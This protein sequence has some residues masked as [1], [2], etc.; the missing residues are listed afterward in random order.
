M[1]KNV[2]KIFLKWHT[3]YLFVLKRFRTSRMSKRR[4]REIAYYSLKI[5]K[6]EKEIK[7]LNLPGHFWLLQDCDDVD[8]P[9]HPRPPWFGAGLLQ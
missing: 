3:Q 4:L 2:R 8:E 6:E 1:Y 5:K 7:A 9:T